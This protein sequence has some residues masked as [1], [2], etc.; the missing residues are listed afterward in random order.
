MRRTLVSLC[1]S[2]ALPLLVFLL[3]APAAFAVP[4]STTLED[5]V[6][7]AFASLFSDVASEAT[8]TPNHFTRVKV[9]ADMAV[10]SGAYVGFYSRA[11]FGLGLTDN[12]SQADVKNTVIAVYTN[13]VTAKV[14]L[15]PPTP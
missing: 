11:L 14:L 10:N 13:V 6:Q 5:K 9:A 1:R 15:E 3:A 2:A 12:T 8:N 4:P 7:I